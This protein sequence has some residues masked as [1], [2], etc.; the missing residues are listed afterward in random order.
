MAILLLL[1]IL[2]PLSALSAFLIMTPMVVLFTMLKPKAFVLHMIPILLLAF[3]LSGAFGVVVIALAIFFLVPSIFM[4]KQYK[5]GAPARKVIVHGFIAILALLLLELAL[6]AWQFD[7]NLTTELSNWLRDALQ[8]FDTQRMLK[9]GWESKYANAI[10]TALPMILL[11]SAAMFAIITHAI[12]RRALRTVDIHVE[13]MP[14]AHTW[15]L[16]RSIVTYYLIAVISS[17]FMTEESSGFW[18]L[19]ITNLLP[20]L[21][22][23]FIVQAVG[24]VFFL[25]HEKKWSKIAPLLLCIP[26]ILYPP[27]FIIGLLDMAFPLRRL[28]TNKSK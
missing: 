28:I 4:G 23:L 18:D 1:S 3:L 22:M 13:G 26:L 8:Q 15:Q 16:P 6:F 11:M 20:I 5:K 25:A 7:V 12:A 14:Q 19:A 2:T 24:F 27:L 10:V 9:E 21:Q 17:F